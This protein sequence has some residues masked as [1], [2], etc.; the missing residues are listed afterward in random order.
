[1]KEPNQDICEIHENLNNEVEELSKIINSFNYTGIPENRAVRHQVHK[2]R[3][4]LW[5]LESKLHELEEK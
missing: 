4:V 2:V 3:S 1:M 5:S